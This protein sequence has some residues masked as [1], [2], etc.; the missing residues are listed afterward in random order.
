MNH[1]NARR[2]AVTACIRPVWARRASEVNL[3]GLHATALPMAETPGSRGH[4][5]VGSHERGKQTH[6]AIWV[7]MKVV[8][9]RAHL[10]L[11]EALDVV[12]YAGVRAWHDQELLLRLVEPL[13]VMHHERVDAVD[14]Q[15]G[16]ELLQAR[17]QCVGQLSDR[18]ARRVDAR[19]RAT[20]R[21]VAELVVNVREQASLLG[22]VLH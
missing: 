4:R 9:Q 22:R 16:E 21:V 13:D 17:L 12:V 18:Y 10:G 8:D 14:H 7:F 3:R 1:A 2:A 6:D 15:P 5:Q 20:D 11:E 19:E